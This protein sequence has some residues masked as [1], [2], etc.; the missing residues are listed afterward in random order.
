MKMTLKVTFVDGKESE[1]TAKFADFVSF[2]RV[3][4]RSV[5]KFESDLRLTDLAWLAWS[6]ET[7]AK[8]TTAKFDPDW[9]ETVETIEP[10]A[11]EDGKPVPLES[12]P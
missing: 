11:D 6:A 9:L 12:N 10:I 3:W 8:R 1:I 4:Q 5:A 7:R 2:E